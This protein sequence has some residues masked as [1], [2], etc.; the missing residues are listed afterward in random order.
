MTTADTTVRLAGIGVELP[1]LARTVEAMESDCILSTPA[2][3]MRAA[4]FQTCRISEV[5]ACELALRAVRRLLEETQTDPLQV[6]L[7]VNVPTLTTDTLVPLDGELSG[8]G[9]EG[10]S[11][12]LNRYGLMRMQRLLGMDNAETLG[13]GELACAGMLHAVWVAHR[14]MDAESWDTAICV[15]ASVTVC[16]PGSREVL[17]SL[18]SDVGCAV[19][20]RRGPQGHRLVYHGRTS[21]GYY[22]DSVASHEELLAAYY[23]TGRRLIQNVLAHCGLTLDDIA[24][25]MP[26]N[27]SLQSWQ[28]MCQILRLPKERVWLDNIPRFAHAGASDAFINLQDALLAGRVR[29]GDR[30]LL[31]GFGLGAR[32]ACTVVEI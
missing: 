25:V 24:C 9:V 4:G 5:P 19:L 21:K 13:L 27:V 7:L 26:N 30:V 11:L 23:P 10:S 22:W 18:L 31:F 20:L 6:Q 2:A 15:N 28:V 12:E 16:S 1:T 3:A 32:W 29:A 8:P 17:H 14:L